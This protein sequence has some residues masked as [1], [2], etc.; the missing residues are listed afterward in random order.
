[1]QMKVAVASGK[2]GTGKTTIA[3]N[4]ALVLSEAHPVQLLDADVEAPNS[5]LFLDLELEGSEEATIDVPVVDEEA[6][7]FC[8]RCSEVCAFNAI[9]VAED[10]VLLFTELCHGCGGCTL[11][12]PEDAISERARPVGIVEWGATPELDFVHG[13]LNPGEA[14]APPVTR[15][16]K[17]H[18]DDSNLTI[19]DAPPGTS[20]TAVEAVKDTDFCVLVTEPTPFGLRDLELAV[21]MLSKLQVPAAV[22]INR[23]DMG[24]EDVQD[25]CQEQELPVLA[26]L[27]FDRR[28][29]EAYATGEPAVHSFE[30]WKNKFKKLAA[31]VL[32]RASADKEGLK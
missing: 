2:G 22:V 21:E 13:I 24:S 20:C 17:R 7:T 16:V 26:R 6:C 10:T 30:A 1:M 8:G 27:P 15:F 4:L 25:Y 32:E 14:L 18:I 5:H 12:C 3:V 31:E 28:L 11:T 9:A 29:A 19:I 23:A